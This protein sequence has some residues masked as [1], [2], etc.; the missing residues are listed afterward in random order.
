[1]AQVWFKQVVPCFIR[2]VSHCM[3]AM[4][5]V[6]SVMLIL[7]SSPGEVQAVLDSAQCDLGNNAMCKSRKLTHSSALIQQGIVVHA[8][9]VCDETDWPDKDHGLVCGDCKVLVDRFNTEYRTCNGYCNAMGRECT[10]AWEEVGD[11]CT[12]DRALKCHEAID[13]SDAICACSSEVR[14]SLPGDVKRCWDQFD[15]V[16]ADEGDTVG[17]TVRTVSAEV[18]KTECM[19]NDDCMSFTLCPQWNSCWM[20]TRKL[21]GSESTVANA[22]CKSFYKKECPSTTG[23]PTPASTPIQSE[24]NDCFGALTSLVADEGV[25]VGGISTASKV[26]CQAAC[27]SSSRC[28]SASFCPQWNGCWF[29]DR[30]L[31]G[32]EDQKSAGIC[33]TLFRK[34]CSG[35]PIVPESPTGGGKV[36][37]VS[38]NLFWWNAFG[39]NPWKGQ[40][41]TDNIKNNLRPDV[42]GM[43]ECDDPRLIEQ[44]TGYV[45]ASEFAGAQG[46]AVKPGVFRIG[47][48]GKQDIQATGKWGPRYVTWAQLIH[49]SGRTFW[50]FNTHWCVHSG[51]G[52]HCDANTR[53]NGAKQMLQIIQQRT[54][55]APAIITGD[56]NAGMSEPGI[57][58][59][60]QNGFKL[61][62]SEWVDAI[63]VSE[64]QWKVH[65]TGRG[66]GAHSDHRPV[67]AE[68]EFV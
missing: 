43:Q 21:S 56:F 23:V 57:E 13:S 22:A 6:I 14:V 66:D 9:D 11:T 26:D 52:H 68:L 64:G 3:A 44:R 27:K 49:S 4:P 62:I 63:F 33:Q 10:G 25:G 29:K 24:S 42:L 5:Q 47:N 35:P 54:Q 45:A 53:Y 46:V 32:S 8:A 20:K 2:S 7:A 34:P 51:N 40:K 41:V 39:Q 50:H 55:G 18:C 61:V 37:V 28:Q 19:A 58:H 16:V 15:A 36:K 30:A 59:F 1:L 48:R 38:Y 31:T 67:F 17:Q 12:V 65:N 60:K